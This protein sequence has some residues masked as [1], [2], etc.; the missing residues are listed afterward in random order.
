MMSR[1]HLLELL[2]LEIQLLKVQQ[3]PLLEVTTGTAS[4][5]M[6]QHQEQSVKGMTRVSLMIEPLLG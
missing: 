3:H 2:H 1:R 5:P 4:Q 6:G